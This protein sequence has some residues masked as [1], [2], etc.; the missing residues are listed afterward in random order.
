MG[1][2]VYA[3][4]REFSCKAGAGKFVAA[5][6]DVCMT[7]PGEP[8]T[9]PGVPIPY[10]NRAGDGERHHRRQQNGPDR[11]KEVWLSDGSL[12]QSTGDKGQIRRQRA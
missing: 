9:P 3:N 2:E 4:G 6:P 1:H 8:A 7:P 11:G 5:F 12:P 10:P